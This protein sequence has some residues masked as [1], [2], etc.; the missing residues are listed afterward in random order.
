MQFLV[1]NVEAAQ[2]ILDLMAVSK[3][4]LQ[5][6]IVCPRE[7]ICRL[8]TQTGDVYSSRTAEKTPKSIPASAMEMEP[9][10]ENLHGDT[11][12]Q[13]LSRNVTLLVSEEKCTSHKNKG[14]ENKRQN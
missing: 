5:H 6:H 2:S 10:L 11:V 8:S 9:A 1:V 3:F 12:D 13:I 14:V 4:L 7:L